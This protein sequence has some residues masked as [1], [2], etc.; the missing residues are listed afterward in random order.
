MSCTFC[1][2]WYRASNERSI[3][4]EKVCEIL[5]S[6]REQGYKYVAFSGGEP[7]MYARF[8][9]VIRFAHELGFYVSVATNGLFIDDQ[10]LDALEATNTS[11]R[12]SLH[13][14]DRSLHQEIVGTD[15]LSRVLASIELLCERGA[16][17][18]IGSTIYEI[19]VHE[20]EALAEYALE[21]NAAFIK[22]S[23]V[24]NVWKG[25]DIYL[26][27]AFYADILTRLVRTTIKH[28]KH[29]NYRKQANIFLDHFVDVMTTR[30]CSAGTD[31]YCGVDTKLNIIPC[32]VLPDHGVLPKASYQ[33]MDDFIE[34]K[35]GFS[36]IY[37]K[38]FADS[39]EGKCADCA[40]KSVCLGGC[41]SLKLSAGLSLT[42]EQP[43]CLWR[44]LN[45]VISQFDRDA[46]ADVLY[47]WQY[48]YNRKVVDG[49]E[50]LGC[51]RHVPVWTL[52]YKLGRRRQDFY[53][54][55]EQNI[56]QRLNA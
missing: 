6:A 14:L 7:M 13:T 18:G 38:N 56:Y 39:L 43:I 36:A 33:S 26:D 20:V 1:G 22:F 28:I 54:P 25:D 27:E 41:L 35:Q 45:R 21:H 19:N 37:D 8:V 29:L 17:Y 46:M 40:F 49:S 16:Y 44:I 34:L 4:F 9:D 23:P 30:R 48:Q 2:A 31:L 52:E 51:I 3:P 32:P 5:A 15:S 53:A 12:V 10:I 11:V 42:S 24:F 50:N 55:S 47:Y